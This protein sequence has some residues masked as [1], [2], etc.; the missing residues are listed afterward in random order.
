MSNDTL[1]FTKHSR[2]DRPSTRWLGGAV[3]PRQLQV[4]SLARMQTQVTASSWVAV[5]HVCQVAESGHL[6]QVNEHCSNAKAMMN[7][8]ETT[9]N[10]RL[11][12][13]QASF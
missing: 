11:A 8:G 2:A 7:L 9:K 1:P 13:E 10:S 5:A 3:V 4:N 12:T 6:Y